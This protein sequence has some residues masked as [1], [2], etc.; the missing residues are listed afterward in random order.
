MDTIKIVDLPALLSGWWDVEET[1]LHNNDGIRWGAPFKTP[2]TKAEKKIRNFEI[3]TNYYS[4]GCGFDGSGFD[5]WMGN[6]KESNYCNF[7]IHFE[8]DELPVSE[9]KTL[10]MDIDKALG[11][12]AEI[13]NQFD[14]LPEIWGKYPVSDY[15]ATK[16]HFNSWGQ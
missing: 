11:F 16:A 2:Y 8:S 3:K 14:Y 6:M 10:K 5:Y 12:L 4:I 13:E 15:K 7:S 1:T 9:I